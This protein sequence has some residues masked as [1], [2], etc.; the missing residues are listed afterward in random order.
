MTNVLVG[1]LLDVLSLATTN[2]GEGAVAA[3]TASHTARS[4]LFPSAH[5]TACSAIPCRSPTSGDESTAR[6]CYDS[7]IAAS[8]PSHTGSSH[9]TSSRVVHGA[10]QQGSP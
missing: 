1:R 4:A 3:T 7:S 2:I 5:T 6:S 8:C 9:S 10:C